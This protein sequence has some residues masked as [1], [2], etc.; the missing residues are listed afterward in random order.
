MFTNTILL[1]DVCGDSRDLPR[2]FDALNII[3]GRVERR[4]DH[5]GVAGVGFRE[6]LVLGRELF[7]LPTPR[8]VCLD[9]HILG[10]VLGNRLDLGAWQG[11]ERKT[12][13]PE[14]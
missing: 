11:V 4:N 6:R 5:V 2:Y 14:K 1:T 8:S 7:A 10:D 3:F 13:K 12:R 9:K